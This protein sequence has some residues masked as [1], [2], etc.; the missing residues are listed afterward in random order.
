MHLHDNAR[1]IGNVLIHKATIAS[2]NTYASQLLSSKSRP[3]DGTV[4]FTDYQSEGIGQRGS[5]WHTESGKAVTMS[6]ILYPQFLSPENHY[7]LTIVAAL[8]VHHFCK[9]YFPENKIS[10]KWPNDILIDN[11]K[12]CGILTQGRVKKQLFQSL[13]LGIGINLFPFHTFP[14]DESRIA[15]LNEFNNELKPLKEIVIDLCLQLDK[16]Y[17][18]LRMGKQDV[19]LKEFYDALYRYDK[20]LRFYDYKRERIRE[21][22]VKGISNNGD[23]L[24][25]IDDVVNTYGIKS[26]KYP[27]YD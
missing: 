24:I 27:I 11:R 15:Y 23:L 5:S 22:I 6:V 1:I 18:L 7:F 12:L 8:A 21:G 17:Q 9:D 26:I 3:K 13:I 2:T 20:K 16:Y 14:G 19:L 25:A 4:I 10:I